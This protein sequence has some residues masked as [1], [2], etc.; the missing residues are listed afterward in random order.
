[1]V[2]IAL[3]KI[4]MERLDMKQDIFTKVVLLTI[5]VALVFIA[6]KPFV[7]SRPVVVSE[8]A[9]VGNP[10]Y[11]PLDSNFKSLLDTKTGNMWAIQWNSQK[12]RYDAIQFEGRIPLEKLDGKMHEVPFERAE[13]ALT[14]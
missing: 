1:M 12:G 2:N 6:A 11:I 5:A 10:Q 3:P 4:Q 14:H 7:G 9:N 8:H 13:N